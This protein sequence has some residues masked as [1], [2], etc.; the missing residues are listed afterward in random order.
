[1]AE[2]LASHGYIV[3][4]NDSPYSTFI[5]VFPD[6]RV[7][8]K[9]CRG[10]PGEIAA[11]SDERVRPANSLVRVWSDE[12]KFILDKPEQLNAGDTSNRIYGRLELNSV[13]IAGH[14]F[15]GAAAAQ[16]CHDDQRC[17]AGI[18][19]DG[20]PFGTVVQ[21]DLKKPFMFLL[22]NHSGESDPL[23]KQIRTNIQNIYD[24]LPEG[25]VWISLDRAKH[26][27]FTDMALTKERLIPR[28]F[29]ATGPIGGKHGPEVEEAF[30]LTFFNV[31]LKGQAGNEIDSLPFHFPDVHL[32]R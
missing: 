29:H 4:G 27:N 20:A 8:E 2:D 16:F 1:M 13:G 32:R 6:G 31:N 5:M 14:S 9:T 12:I 11:G 28:L 18:D 30:V 15:G 10:S 21:T 17:K 22:E 7:T 25:R 24:S 26:F 19:I 3:V 23:S